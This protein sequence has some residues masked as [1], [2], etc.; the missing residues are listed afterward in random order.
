MEKLKNKRK[1]LQ[2]KTDNKMK[3]YGENDH[4]GQIK[5][6]KK[7]L[8]EHPTHKTKYPEIASTIYH[9]ILHSKHPKA[10][11]KT[12]RKME[13]KGIKKMGKKQ[14]AKLYAKVK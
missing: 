1:K 12:V 4:Q 5:I 11:E 6:N 10:H 2:F 3:W 14:K 7:L 8:K 9:E 13:T